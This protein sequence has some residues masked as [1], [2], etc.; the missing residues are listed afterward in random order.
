VGI[1]TFKGYR[2]PMEAAAKT[3]GSIGGIVKS[4][5]KLFEHKRLLIVSISATGL[6]G[7]QMCLTTYLVLFAYEHFGFSVVLSGILLLIS[8]V[9]GSAGRVVW[10]I[11][12][13]KIFNGKRI[14]ILIIIAIITA[15]CSVIVTLLPENTPFWSLAPII[16]LFGF[17]ISGFN[18]IWMNLASELVPRE[19]AGLS[20]GFSILF[21]SAGVI[22][23][24]PLFGY[25]IDK[26]GS[27][28]YGWFFISGLMIVVLALLFILKNQQNSSSNM[29]EA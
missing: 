1:V 13:D 29:T 8:E 17:A 27:Y 19:L 12:S 11:I 7:S 4:L 2:D 9:S 25:L 23:M 14:I 22:I 20:S 16:S 28:M 24:P 21:G 26:S 5:G 3:Q 10:G 15:I 18:G 6:N